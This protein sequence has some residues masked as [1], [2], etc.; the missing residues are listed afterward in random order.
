MEKSKVE[1]RILQSLEVIRNENPFMPQTEL[2][3]KVLLKEIVA[4]HLEAGTKINQEQLAELLGMSRTP[5]RDALNELEKDG[6]VV[7]NSNGGFSVYQLR[8]KDYVDFYDFRIMLEAQAAYLA[9][10]NIKPEQLERLK[11]NVDAFRTAT[12]KEDIATM[13]KLDIAFHQLIVEASDNRY[14]IEAHEHIINKRK[15]FVRY[16]VKSGR[17]NNAVKWHERC[18]DAIINQDEDGAKKSIEEHLKYYIRGLY[19][20]L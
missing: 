16:M 8:I 7:K 17:M 9:A 5:V 4:T 12:E 2:A 18:L 14:I 3:Y 11:K 1:K 13:R 15:M 6:Y 20:V 19:D 10:R